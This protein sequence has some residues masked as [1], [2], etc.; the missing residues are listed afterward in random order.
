MYIA[1][2]IRALRIN[3]HLTEQD[4]AIMLHVDPVT[5]VH[6]ENGRLIPSEQEIIAIANVFHVSVDDI[7]GKKVK[8]PNSMNKY[9][10]RTRIKDGITGAFKGI[11]KLIFVFVIV[12]IVIYLIY[13]FLVHPEVFNFT[14]NKSLTCTVD[15]ETYTINIKTVGL[16]KQDEIL[17]VQGDSYL[18]EKVD[19]NKYTNF[20]DAC[21]IIEAKVIQEGGSCKR[22]G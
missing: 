5:I 14:K 2:Q 1:K 4:L 7:K 9:K 22:E 18:M 15:N 16:F 20:N 21:D 3:A 11:F 12:A 19:F 13:L 8:V 6:W 17:N 10:T